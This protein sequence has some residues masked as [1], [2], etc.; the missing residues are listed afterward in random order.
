MS[1]AIL[2]SRDTYKCLGCEDERT[3]AVM[4]TLNRGEKHFTTLCEDCVSWILDVLRR[5]DREED[6]IPKKGQ[7]R[8]YRLEYGTPGM[9]LVSTPVQMHTTDHVGR[10]MTAALEGK[11]G[12]SE[13]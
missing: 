13:D 7:G 3:E 12:S 4:Y 5:Q 2:K 10:M 8:S 1:W 11:K 9:A 6:G